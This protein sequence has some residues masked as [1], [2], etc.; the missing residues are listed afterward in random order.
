M[1]NDVGDL[2]GDY[3]QQQRLQ[4][5]R[6]ERQVHQLLMEGPTVGGRAVSLPMAP[7]RFRCR[8]PTTPL[9]GVRFVIE[10]SSILLL[11]FLCIVHEFSDVTMAK[12]LHIGNC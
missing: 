1:R 7:T 5:Q 11:V 8:G 12:Q 2:F 6:N 4:Q 3:Q 9:A 10:F